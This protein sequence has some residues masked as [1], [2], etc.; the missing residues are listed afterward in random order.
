VSNIGLNFG[1]GDHPEDEDASRVAE[2]DVA[3]RSG[4]PVAPRRGRRRQRRRSGVRGCLPFLVVLAVL[5]AA[6]WFG[7]TYA[8]DRLESAFAGPPDYPGPG[9]GEV[10]I[11]VESGATS[12]A[13][14]RTL[15]EAGVVK[16]VE[17]FTD[18]ARKNPDQSRSIQVG[19]YTLKKRMKA[20][21]A[22]EVLIDP[23]N[24]VQA[25]VTVPEGAR[26]A[27]IVDSIVKNTDIPRRAVDQALKRP[28]AIGLPP[29]ADGNP[30]GYLYPATYTVPPKMTAVQLLSEMVEKTKQVEQQLDIAHGAARLGLSKE[31]VLIVASLLEH[32]ANRKQDYPKV[33]RVLYNRLEAGMPLQLDSTVRYVSGREG[34][35]F[36]TDEERADESLYNTYEHTGLPPGPIGSPG[37]ATIR[38]ALNP[39]Q[40]DWLYFETVNL[41]T[42]E[43]AFAS[44]YA[45]HQR[46][47]QELRDWCAESGS[48]LC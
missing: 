7:G 17:A 43:T 21:D 19:F 45:E 9:T 31:D 33:A 28:G 34:D 47:V 41:E 16:S 44:S 8:L 6:A 4:D 30:E 14:G 29:E 32:E 5:A 39:A 37:E 11:E 42:G 15:E 26:V 3:E 46:N 20:S 2:D 48:D 23:D 1:A 25:T 13:I 35:V 38:A 40:G 27:D 12:T 10:T 22:L 36:T 24:L 18:A